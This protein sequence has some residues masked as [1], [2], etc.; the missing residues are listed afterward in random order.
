MISDSKNEAP[1][2][3]ADMVRYA[4]NCAAG[5]SRVTLP[6]VTQRLH[7]F[8]VRYTLSIDQTYA[9]QST[10]AVEVF[11]LSTKSWGELWTLPGKDFAPS[12]LGADKPS[13]QIGLQLAAV[14]A[15]RGGTDFDAIAKSWQQVFNRLFEHAEFVLR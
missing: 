3:T 13:G 8:P 4:Y 5:A 1:T 15:A 14:P 6:Q 2:I 9:Y 11:S 7:G 10:F 12:V